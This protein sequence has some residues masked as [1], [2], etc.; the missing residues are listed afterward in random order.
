MN[1]PLVS[2][3]VPI[4][5]VE[6]YLEQCIESIVNQTYTN[7]EILLLDDGSPDNCG[8]IC[9]QWAKKDARIRVL[10]K[11]NS[12]L[13]DTRN[14]GIALATGTYLFMPDSDDYL[15]PDTIEIMV[16]YALTYQA[17]CVLGG[18]Q[19]LFP[20]GTLVIHAGTD[21]PIICRDR[22]DMERYIL[23][24]LIGSEYINVPHLSQS[25]SMK[26]YLRQFILDNNLYFLP[27]KE[28]GMEDFYFNLCFF[29]KA[30][31]AVIIP[32]NNYI[33]RCNPQS[34]TTTFQ[35]ERANRL[36]RLY[37]LLKKEPILTDPH[38]YEQMLAAN[39][40]GSISVHIKQIVGSNQPDKIAKIAQQMEDPAI[41]EMLSLCRVTKIKFPLS[42]FCFLMK[43]RMNHM[44]Y[45]LVKLFLLLN[46]Q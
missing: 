35:P 20:D 4:Y 6:A 46:R 12:G 44:I 3:V 38:E 39:I 17:Q 34:I 41:R 15:L 8:R 25:A 19:R 18:Y 7:L 42:L 29:R 33:Y 10:H 43:Y 24:R 40:L 30:D 21:T 13:S 14:T 26:L 9:D 37:T 2:I 1:K 5:N 36:I 28:I 22:Q 31:S 23:Y 27:T 16:R 11:E 45:F 32:E